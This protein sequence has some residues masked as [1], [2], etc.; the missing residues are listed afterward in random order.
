MKI[1][2]ASLL[3]AKEGLGGV[4]RAFASVLNIVV[5]LFC[6][7]SCQENPPVPEPNPGYQLGRGVFILN[8]GNFQWGNASLDYYD[9]END[10]LL[11]GIYAAA[12]DE[13]LGDVLQ[14]LYLDAIQSQAFLVVNNSGKVEVINPFTH[15]RTQTITGLTSPR[16]LYPVDDDKYYVSDLFS[17]K[18]SIVDRTTLGVTGS[19]A[20]P[21]WS[22]QMISLSNNRVYVSS[23]DRPYLY[24]VDPTADVLV[25]SI[26]MVLGGAKL[27]P[28]AGAREG[29]W[30]FCVGSTFHN[31]SGGFYQFQLKEDGSQELE[32]MLGHMFPADRYPSEMTYDAQGGYI[33][34]VEGGAVYK[35]K[36]DQTIPTTPLI[37]ANGHVF[38]GLGYDAVDDRLYVAD[39][40]DYVQRGW[41]RIYESDGTPV[42]SFRTG[43]IPNAFV[44][45][46]P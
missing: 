5:S 43:M 45:F 32:G 36:E 18:L 23:R 2:L 27:F 28:T 10:T 37:P 44:F 16:H 46:D 9:I 29:F 3:Q 42:D 7:T 33:Y 15:E 31:V 14:S 35:M 41:V 8:E 17:G 21:G 34:F 20:V 30:L 38:Y 24:V 12:N 40:M 22:E 39:A 11:S 6:L 1:T 4:K 26:P 13:P 19:V 25:D